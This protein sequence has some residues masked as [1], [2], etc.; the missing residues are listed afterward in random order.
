MIKKRIFF[1][2]SV[3]E[4]LQ[5]E[6]LK[7][8]KKYLGSQPSFAKATEGKIRWLA[9][10]NLHITLI[11]PWYTGD[12]ESV[13]KKLKNLEIKSF[14]IEFNRV[15]YGPDPKRPRLIWAEDKA[16][17]GIL[18]LKSRLEEILDKKPEKRPFTLHLTIAR[19]RPETFSSFSIQQLDERV[20]WQEKVNSFVLMEAHLS[21]KGADYEILETFNLS[22]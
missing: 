5:K 14:N 2:V 11:P 7:W 15:T 9:G 12:V 20:L 3:S 19:F 8:Q 17:K 18:E 16:P 10:K 1:A 21:P 22:T 13:I 4:D 6:I